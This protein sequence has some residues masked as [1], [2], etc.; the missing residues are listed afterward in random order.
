MKIL[1]KTVL[2]IALLLALSYAPAS[3]DVPGLMSYQGILKDSNGDPVTIP[4]TVIF[5]IYDDPSLS[6]PSNIKWQETHVIDADD[7]GLFAILLGDG[8]VAVPITDDVFNGPDRWLGIQVEGETEQTPRTRMTASAYSQRV[9]TVDGSTG[10]TISGDVAIASD[11][12]IDGDIIATGKATIGPNHLNTGICGF[13]SGDSNMVS[14][15]MS[16]VAGGYNNKAIGDESFIGGGR[17][18]LVEGLRSSI[19][20]GYANKA[21]GEDDAIGGGLYL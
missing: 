15:N 19:C 11:L 5:T 14:G 4:T 2:T 17:H 7:N 20:G 9:S 6:D 13:V 21:Y 12:N 18:N 10:G 8:V 3:A 16:T 1:Y